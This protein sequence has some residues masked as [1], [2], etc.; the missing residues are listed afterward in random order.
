[1]STRKEMASTRL[2]NTYNCAQSVLSSF[3]DET[4]LDDDLALKIATGLGAGMGRTGEVCGAVTGGILVL[5]LRHGRG[6]TEGRPSTEYTYLKTVEL[7]DRFT[8]RHGSCLCRDLLR[9]YDLKTEEGC[10]RA[11]AE[12][13]MGRICRPCVHSVIEILEEMKSADPA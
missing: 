4:G 10:Q 5:G 7:M 13:T 1:M 8:A 3:R 11:K 6:T 2:Q 9:G 12:D